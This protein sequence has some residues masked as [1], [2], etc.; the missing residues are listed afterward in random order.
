V[1]S[2]QLKET[3]LSGVE[4]LLLVVELLVPEELLEHAAIATNAAGAPRAKRVRRVMDDCVIS[5]SPQGYW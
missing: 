1:I 2:G 3:T 5:V 4:T